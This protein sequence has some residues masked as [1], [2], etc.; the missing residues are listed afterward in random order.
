MGHG[1]LGDCLDMEAVT[2]DVRLKGQSFL[3]AFL[4]HRLYF[5]EQFQGSKKMNGKQKIPPIWPVL[6]LLL[7]PQFP[8]LFTSCISVG[9]LLSLISQ[10]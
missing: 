2:S 8:L 3:D 1:T 5:L 10:Y 6:H 9:P 7:V 4:K